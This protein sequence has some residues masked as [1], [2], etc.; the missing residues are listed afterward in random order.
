MKSK[1]ASLSKS[2]GLLVL[3][4]GSF[5]TLRWGLYEPFVIPSGSMMPTLLINDHILVSKYAFGLRLPFTSIWLTQPHLPS[6]GDVVV[7]RS[8]EQDDYYM[9]KRVVGLPGDTVSYSADAELKI[10]G[11]TIENTEIEFPS[12]MAQPELRDDPN[13]YVLT[14]EKLGEH[15]HWMLLEK[16]AIHAVQTE[17]VIGPGMIFLMGDSRDRSRDSRFWGE[18]P[19]EKLLGQARWIWLSCQETVSEINFL[20]DPRHIRWQRTFHRIE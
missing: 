6:R 18:L 5:L 11:Q 3:A 4:I 19:A 2:L 9:I 13:R 15:T 7:F 17:H 12:W 1:K 14:N 20:C 10:N 16:E 8:V